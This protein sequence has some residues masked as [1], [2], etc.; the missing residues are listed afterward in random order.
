MFARLKWIIAVLYTA[1]AIVCL[2]AVRFL[3]WWVSIP[4]SAALGA[5]VGLAIAIIERWSRE[6]DSAR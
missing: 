1:V 3:P 5:G 2:A 6:E 4:L